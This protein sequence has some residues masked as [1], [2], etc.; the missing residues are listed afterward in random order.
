MWELNQPGEKT[1]H[2]SQDEQPFNM[3]ARHWRRPLMGEKATHIN[4][5]SIEGRCPTPILIWCKLHDLT[6]QDTH[7][8]QLS[9]EGL[10]VNYFTL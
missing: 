7:I 9:I 4:Q 5:L 3:I 8:N 1:N 10:K 6:R 2:C